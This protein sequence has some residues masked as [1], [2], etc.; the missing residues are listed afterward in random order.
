VREELSPSDRSSLAA[1]RGPINM[2]VGGVMVF[3]RKPKLTRAMVLER[4]GQR[5]HLIPRLRQ[6]LEEPPLGIAS[7]VWTDDVNFDLD[8]HIRQASLPKPGGDAELGQFVGREFSHRLDR[9]RPLWEI[10]LIEGLQGGRP[11]LLLK[12]HHALVDGMAALALG[13]LLLD[14]TREPLEI[15]PP[16]QE[17]APLP[18]DMRK[19]VTKLATTPLTRAA[20]PVF[21]TVMRALDPNPRRAVT[22]AIKAA[23]DLRK[24]T[25]VALE[26]AKN[27]PTAPM[28][29]INRTISSNRRYTVAKADLATVK[30]V[31]KLA[32]G[33][34]ND[35]ILAVVTGMLASYIEAAEGTELPGEARMTPL[36]RDPIAL[37]PVSIRSK[38]ESGELGNRISTVFVDLPT[39]E[40][41]LF[42]RIARIHAEMSGIKDS[43]AIRAGEIMVGMTGL[44]PPLVS[45]LMVMAMGQVRAFNM[46]VSNM[47]GPQQPLYMTGVRATEI[48]PLAPLNP[49]NQGLTVG[50]IS[51]DGTVCFGIL[52]D[53]DLEPGLSVATE[54][55]HTAL[56]ELEAAAT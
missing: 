49:S 15:A 5:L 37:V 43:A 31:G 21:D 44:A 40:P 39:D 42:A 54:G 27:R 36:K 18:Y 50:V 12:A 22:D 51:Y 28:L 3:E 19:H 41:D 29:P 48:Y 14:P 11:A 30:K 8:W 2:A 56:A 16:E 53:R 9:S 38:N 55:L 17:W 45:G 52:A 32:G 24:A 25:D 1:E 46:V 13:A 10:T 23:Q 35:T 4:V 7:P 26:L 6:R 47:P 34:I 20:R 33:T